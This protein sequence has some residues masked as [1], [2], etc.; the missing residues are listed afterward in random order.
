MLLTVHD[1]CYLLTLKNYIINIIKTLQPTYIQ[2]EDV[3][4]VLWAIFIANLIMLD[5]ALNLQL[6]LSI[7]YFVYAVT[8]QVSPSIYSNS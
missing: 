8:Q 2:I 6:M 3:H 4:L 1:M 7:A 5:S